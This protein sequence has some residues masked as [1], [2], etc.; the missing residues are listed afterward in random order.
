VFC[1]AIALSALAAPPTAVDAI[2]QQPVKQVL[3]LQSFGGDFAPY[4]LASSIFRSHL[5]ATWAG[6]VEFNEVS[7]LGTLSE[8]TEVEGALREYLIAIREL[9][10]P[11]LVVAVGGVAGPFVLAHREDL[12]PATPALYIGVAPRLV[13]DGGI[14]AND[15]SVPLGV[16]LPL[17]VENILTV[18]PRTESIAIMVG[19]SPI[20]LYWRDELGREL[21]PFEDRVRLVWWDDL[22]GEEILDR[23]AA[24]PE[25]SAILYTLFLVDAAGIPH[26]DKSILGKLHEVAS[27]PIFGLFDTQLGEGLVGGPLLPVS[28]LASLAAGAAAGILQGEPPE[29]FR[30][31][32]VTPEPVFDGRELLRW[33]IPENR[34]PPGS[35][36]RFRAPSPWVEY[37]R[38]I[39]A[40]LIIILIQAGLVVGLLAK[41]SR[42]R[43]AEAEVRALSRRLLSAFED[44]RRRLARELHDD[45]AQRLARLAIDAARLE[46][47][48]GPSPLREEIGHLS[49][50]VHSLSRRLH[51][52][53]LDN[54]GLEEALRAEAEQFVEATGI[55]VEAKLEEILTKPAADASLCLFRIA[56]ESLRNVERHARAG[57]VE[58]AL[59]SARGG[60]ELEVR[61]DGAGFDPEQAREQGIGLASMRERAHLAGGHLEIS[62]A[63]GRGTTVKAWVPAARTA[64]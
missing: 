37:W 33:D 28:R 52:S 38:P 56:Q 27:A 50:D 14:T 36:V 26:T 17:L 43:T 40:V 31:P 3:I 13:H 20:E 7:V 22:S 47:A 41:S 45:V 44:E 15:A 23:A 11:D 2:A 6:P 59:R 1:A 30:L 49:V 19:S 64:P 24:L 18:L 54:L 32:P 25:H 5:V 35:T 63:P 21:R 12:F 55:D 4:N 42:L 9:Q 62:S 46:G 60:C 39:L 57:R 61:D 8:G 48:G 58:L 16:D 29:R 51:P 10:Q 34:L 53:L